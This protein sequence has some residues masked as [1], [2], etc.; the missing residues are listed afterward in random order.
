MVLSP[1]ECVLSTPRT[2][3]RGQTGLEAMTVPDGVTWGLGTGSNEP[4]GR[5]L[6]HVQVPTSILGTHVWQGEHVQA[7]G[8]GGVFSAEAKAWGP[9]PVPLTRGLTLD[10][11]ASGRVR[12]FSAAREARL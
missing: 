1:G 12:I 7:G 9:G 2:E 4:T 3:E 10:A 5:S 11:S 6:G 8:Q